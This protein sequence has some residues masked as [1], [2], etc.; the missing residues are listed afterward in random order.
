MYSPILSKS[1]SIKSRSFL[2]KTK[3]RIKTLVLKLNFHNG[4]TVKDLN[5]NVYAVGGIKDKL[6][7][8]Y[9]AGIT[10]VFCPFDNIYDVEL[11]DSITDDWIKY[12]DIKFIKTILDINFLRSSFTSDVTLYMHNNISNFIRSSISAPQLQLLGKE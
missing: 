4:P 1:P 7:G 10:L 12:L 6:R 5:G 9:V 11:I 8:A 2:S 3:F